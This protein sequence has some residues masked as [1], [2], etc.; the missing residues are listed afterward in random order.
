MSKT[1]QPQCLKEFLKAIGSAKN[2][3]D[4]TTIISTELKSLLQA[5]SISLPLS[6]DTLIKLIF[7][8]LL[9]HDITQ[10]HFLVIQCLASKQPYIRRLGYLF[11]SNVI[12][13]DS[14]VRIMAIN[15]IL[16]DLKGSS[17]EVRGALITIS[18]IVTKETVPI[19]LDKVNLCTLD[20]SYT[21]AT[22]ILMRIQVVSCFNHESPFVRNVATHTFQRF[23]CLET[24]ILAI[25]S[26]T[27]LFNVDCIRLIPVYSPRTTLRRYTCSYAIRMLPSWRAFFP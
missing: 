10:L 16:S 15:N 19:F 6:R 26:E 4:E 12:S 7:A 20:C 11:C 27:F 1:L 9:G 2:H 17:L 3:Q 5:S 21:I 25:S 14:S 23:F 13:K 24:P 18:Q 8:H 22:V